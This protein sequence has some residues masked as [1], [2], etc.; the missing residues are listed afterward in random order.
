MKMRF[1]W[2]ETSSLCYPFCQLWAD[3]QNPNP[4]L[5]K[6]LGCFRTGTGPEAL[7]KNTQATAGK[8]WAWR[9]LPSPVCVHGGRGTNSG[10]LAPPVSV[11]VVHLYSQAAHRALMGDMDAPKAC[12]EIKT[13]QNHVLRPQG[14]HGGQPAQKG[15]PAQACAPPSGL[16]LPVVHLLASP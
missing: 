7:Y 2:P 5:G 3:A 11:P 6:G 13:K 8:S 14:K 1:L 9:A 12:R 16:T 15:L 10:K 4:R